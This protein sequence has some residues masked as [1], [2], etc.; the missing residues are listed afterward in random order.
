MGYYKNLLI[1]AFEGSKSAMRLIAKDFE[2]KN[3]LEEAV[4]WYQ[5]SGDYSK[6]KELQSRIGSFDRDSL[7]KES[8]SIDE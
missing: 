8:L 6:V 1:E 3:K 5:A 4:K 7:D 2:L